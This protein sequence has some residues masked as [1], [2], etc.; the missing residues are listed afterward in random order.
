VAAPLGGGGLFT[1]RWARF[2]RVV[3]V[4]GVMVS[5]VAAVAWARGRTSSDVVL[6]HDIRLLGRLDN[7]LGFYRF[8]YK[9]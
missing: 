8:S 6:K 4:C 2:P 3:V 7:G 9:Q 1:R 5:V